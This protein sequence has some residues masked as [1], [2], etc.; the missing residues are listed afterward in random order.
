[1]YDLKF[2]AIM[3]SS[4]K[5]IILRSKK[6]KQKYKNISVSITKYTRHSTKAYK[7]FLFFLNF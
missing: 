6:N 2:R 5:I 1:M 3:Q 4:G 7:Y